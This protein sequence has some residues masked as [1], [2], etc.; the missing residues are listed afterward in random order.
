MRSATRGL[1]RRG[2]TH[3]I[4]WARLSG[5]GAP[6][7]IRPRK[8]CL[9]RWPNS[10]RRTWPAFC[11]ISPKRRLEIARALDDE[12]LADVLE[13]MAEHDA[14]QIVSQ[15]ESERA[16]DVLEEMDPDDAVDLLSDLTPS[17]PANCCRW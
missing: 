14:V 4:E 10:G 12:R 11:T 2:Q 13:E 5:V 15:L 9:S 7:P 17:R 6:R 1:A 16:A 8:A 3:V